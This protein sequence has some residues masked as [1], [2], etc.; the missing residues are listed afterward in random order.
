MNHYPVTAEQYIKRETLLGCAINAVIALFF[1]ALLFHS[2]PSI[3]LWGA[4]GIAVDLIPTVFMLTL[5]GSLAISL[6]TRQ[7]LRRGHVGQQ[8]AEAASSWIGAL[9]SLN[10]LLRTF[11][12]AVLMTFSV[13]PLTC[14]VLMTLAIDALPFWP[15]VAF[16]M[17]Y[18]AAIGAL[19][20]PWILKAALSVNTPPTP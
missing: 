11:I 6:I 15:F 12:V 7:R 4:K 2:T 14:L 1:A 20:A 9:A 16:K 13:V 5:F 19:S 17:V 18:A 3:P 10:V 8:R